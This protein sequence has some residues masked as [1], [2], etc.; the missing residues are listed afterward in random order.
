MD[1]VT[2]NAPVSIAPFKPP[3]WRCRRPGLWTCWWLGRH[4]ATARKKKL[5]WECTIFST[6][7]KPSRFRFYRL[8]MLRHVMD[9]P[10]EPWSFKT[11]SR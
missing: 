1:I 9:A 5:Y 11:L 7:A 8:W 3:R 2:V 4:Y 6:Y 10:I